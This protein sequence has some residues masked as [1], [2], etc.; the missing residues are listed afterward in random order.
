MLHDDVGRTVRAT[1][2]D[3]MVSIVTRRSEIS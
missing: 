2:P 1:P 3:G